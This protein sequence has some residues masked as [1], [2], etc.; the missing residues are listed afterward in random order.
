MPLLDYSLLFFLSDIAVCFLWTFLVLCHWRIEKYKSYNSSAFFP[1]KPLMHKFFTKYSFFTNTLKINFLLPLFPIL[2]YAFWIDGLINY[3]TTVL[4]LFIGFN[5]GF[6]ITIFG[7]FSFLIIFLLKLI[8]LKKEFMTYKLKI[9]KNVDDIELFNLEVG[10]CYYAASNKYFLK[11]L[12]Q[13]KQTINSKQEIHGKEL[14]I[15]FVKNFNIFEI[16]YKY[17]YCCRNELN[18]SFKFK[19]SQFF[20]PKNFNALMSFIN[21]TTKKNL[22]GKEIYEIFIGYLN[23]FELVEQN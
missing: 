10:D 20:T 17:L 22:Y 15:F 3:Y 23:S 6:I 13:F 18:L 4:N 8:Y 21:R 9:L 14:I 1:Q 11:K 2:L 5:V 7:S 12:T 16:F 19:V